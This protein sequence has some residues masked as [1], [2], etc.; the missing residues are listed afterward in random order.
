LRSVNGLQVDEVS[1]VIETEPAKFGVVQLTEKLDKDMIPSYDDAKEEVKERLLIIKR[2]DFL[3]TYIDKLI[4]D[5]NLEI[6]RYSE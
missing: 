2:K 4:A 6:K 3:R 5:H 1:L